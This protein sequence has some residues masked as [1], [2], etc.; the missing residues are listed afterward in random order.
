MGEV[1]IT[2][3]DLSGV[4]DFERE[5]SLLNAGSA[6]FESLSQLCKLVFS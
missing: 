3:F 1:S 4:L 5:L 6:M 2:K